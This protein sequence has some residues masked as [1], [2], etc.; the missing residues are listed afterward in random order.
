VVAF[1]EVRRE[2]WEGLL[3]NAPWCA[4][5]VLGME[6]AGCVVARDE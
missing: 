1:G 4:I 2:K 3:R 5:A 6:L